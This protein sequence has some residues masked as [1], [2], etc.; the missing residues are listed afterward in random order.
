MTI[1][2]IAV[3][4]GSIPTTGA[5]L[6]T[7]NVTNTVSGLTG[8]ITV[9]YTMSGASGT[10]TS[11]LDDFTLNGS[12]VSAGP[13][14][15]ATA[16]A[17]F[18]PLCVNAGPSGPKSFTIIGTGLSTADITVGALSGFTYSTTDPGTYT[19]SLSIGQTG[20]NFSRDVF[21]KFDPTAVMSYNGNIPVGGGGATSINVAASGSG[22]DTPPTVATGA[23]TAITTSSAT[24]A[25]TLNTSL[26]CGT[27]IAYGIEYSTT[28]G[29]TPGTG[30]SVPST[31]LGGTSFSSALSGLAP[32]TVYYT[33]AYATRSSET[34]YGAQGTFTTSA[35]AAPVAAAGSS[36]GANGFTANWGSVPGATGY[37]LDVYTISPTNDEDFTDANF[38]SNPAWSGSTSEYSILTASPL[39]SG[40]ASTDASYLGSSATT[41]TSALTMPSSEVLE[42]KF[43]WGSA[44]YSPSNTNYFGVI[45]MSDAVISDIDA[46]FNG[47]YLQIGASGSND[48]IE[49]WRST[50]LTKTKLG[51]FSSS[52]IVGGAALSNGLNVRVTRS[53]SGVFELFYS[54]GFTYATTPT[55]SAGT[56]TDNTYNVSSRFGIYTAFANVGA[57]R[58]VYI[59]NIVLGVGE[60]SVSGYN[61]LSVVGTSQAVTGLSPLTTYYYRVRT[62][63][64]TCTSANSN[65]ITVNTTAGVT[66]T[67]TA[68]ALTGFGNVCINTTAGPNS[69]HVDGFNLT[70]ADVTVGALSGFTYSTTAL[71]TYTS[72]LSITQPGGTFSQ[73][74]F[75]KF[76]PTMVQAYDGDI[77]IGG[78]G[79][80]GITAAVVGS[81]IDTEPLVTTG[82]ASAITTT[83]ATVAGTL[84]VSTACGTV[85]AYGIEY[86]TTLGFANGSGT[87]VPSTNL[88][89]TN[90]SS[91]LSGLASCTVYYTHAY[92]TRAAGTTYGSEGSFTTASIDA[93]V[94]TAGTSVGTSGFTANWG[95]V[96]GATDYRLDVYQETLTPATDLFFSEYV[97]GSGNN[98]YIEI[99][100]GTGA[101]VNLADYELQVFANGNNTP[102]SNTLA[103]TLANNTTIVYKNSSA[104]LYGGASTNSSVVNF[105][106]NDAFALYKTSTSSFVDI[107]GEI[108]DNPGTA[109]T[110]GG[111]STAGRTLVR[112]ASVYS[113]VT[114][115]PVGL[116]FPTLATEWVGY[117]EDDV[118]HLGT[119]TFDGS[120]ISLVPGY[121]DLTVAG[122]SQAV[123]GLD[124]ATTYLYRV[125]AVAA[126][127]TSPN[128]NVIPVTTDAVNTYYSRAN[129]NVTDNIW[130]NTPS[131]TA[132]PA[133]WTYASKM[134]VQSGDTVTNTA[135]VDLRS[136][137]VETGGSLVL[138]IAT[139]FRV[140]GDGDFSGTLTAND[141]SSLTF[142][143]A[144]V[145]TSTAPLNLYNLTA[146]VPGDLITDA[147]INIRG[148]LRLI[149]GD[150]DASTGN[151]TLTSDAVRTGR[152]SKVEGGATY[153]GNLT[154][155]RYIPG[156]QTNWRFLGS[157]VA[158]RT[159][160]N[161]QDDFFTA[162]YPGSAYPNFYDPPGSGI[163][164]P[165]IRY[166]N[167]TDVTPDQNVGIVGVTSNS[168][169]LTVGQ[170]FLAWSGDNF[171][172]TAAFTV[173]VTGTP[174]IA[175]TPITLPMSFTSS[176]TVAEDG[177]NLVSNPLPSAISFDSISRGSDV[178]NK[179][180]IFNPV[181]GNHQSYSAGLGTGQVNG[182]I[183]S[184]Q[185]FWLK[186]DGSNVTTTVSESDKIND[187]AGGVF[188]G[189]VMAV[190]PIVRLTVASALN[191]FSDET[192]FV[193]D[194]GTPG[195]DAEDALKF[196]FHTFGAPQV[197]TKASNG[198]AL[199][200]NFFGAY[201]ADIS[202]PVTVDVDVTGTYTISAA[203]AGMQGLSCISL[204]DLSTGSITPM[205]DGAS[206]SFAI[207]ADD[208]ASTPRFLLHGTAPL[209]LYTEN[210]TCANNPN[211][212][213]TV[214][215][216]NGPVDIT[217]KDA[218]G[219]ILLSQNGIE[220]G[221]AIND[222]LGAGNYSV[223]ISPMGA[224]GEVAADFSIEA[225]EAISTLATSTA[226]TCPT[227][228]DGSVNVDATGGT[229][230]LA[231]LWNNGTTGPEFIGAAG[232]HQV[233]VTDENGCS[234]TDS[235]TIVAGEGAIAGFT[236]GT[237]V[238][239]APVAFTNT[240][241]SSNAWAW[242]FGDGNTSTEMNPE[243]IYTEAGTYTVTLTSTDGTCSDISTQEIVVDITTAVTPVSNANAFNVYATQQQLVIDHAFGNAPVDVAV[244][245]AT[246]RL[247]MSRNG[248][249]KPNT[250]TL[251][252]REL[253]TGVWFVRV[254]SGNT[255][256]TFRVPLVR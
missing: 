22:V 221:V 57:T 157:P 168:Q 117:A 127:C 256:R 85:T 36:V 182:K 231:Y 62:V 44:N 32:C 121:N 118:S 42:W 11:R 239:N 7:T 16:L 55:T 29:Y 186:A 191:T 126:S 228:A 213:A 110:G 207:N 76:T 134:V 109:W 82:A 214:V 210:A 223:H 190:R 138:N 120:I 129:G 131:G 199:S 28:S 130:S 106:G 78:G 164:W 215:V 69:F 50:G 8:T 47:Y 45:L 98:K 160:A 243:H 88:L 194:Q 184:S 1:N 136:V 101:T 154:V 30:T 167:E 34:T 40:S 222:V 54:T 144:S 14:L 158:G 112:K 150:F 135:D 200:I 245:D 103:G 72:T 95:A 35:I 83:S 5:A 196:T 153:T 244:Y 195:T 141:G 52:P 84:D 227:S 125:R 24:V 56:L 43:S 230:D 241:T 143:V 70:T 156:G 151:V 212:T 41:G 132:G 242:D 171:I 175:T 17:A 96:A 172:S 51:D 102:T 177:W 147:T 81:G 166:Y 145:V 183:Q 224:C 170:G 119:H 255:E 139:D 140:L 169:P 23:A 251:S 253:S 12:V 18:G 225:P 48:R 178:E 246:G 149:D 68:G 46:S 148:S 124:P 113:G 155:Q 39:P 37:K 193:F 10:G 27:I 137:S 247:V 59:D 197:A 174:N 104:T 201:T 159:V 161:W 33:H 64:A 128:S 218:F 163:F 53:G 26:S 86:S 122:T 93:P 229:G 60:T 58:R 204:E 142:L 79:A 211:G 80:T 108:G 226:T 9:V 205:T 99:F 73:D 116:G 3:G 4:S 66:P 146:N 240:S 92:A 233:I 13:T 75:V 181:T 49:L 67:L 237:A 71:G 187:L 65:V 114:T 189:D 2:G 162:G 19:T 38:T 15:S 90:F 208:D 235:F 31:N 165:S 152:L 97:E 179:Y 87:A 236:T 202:I 100:N 77:A 234:T 180:W 115:N 107:I 219:N 198:D 220:N 6:G 133:V 232:E 250:I 252:D 25:G 217:W 123:T 61:D 185:A 248:V 94:A 20:G 203:I 105:N 63:G 89:G 254:T 21:V 91:A 111:L 74:I 209:P 192:V 188:G 176:G 249:V 206:Y 173:D 238:E 216:A